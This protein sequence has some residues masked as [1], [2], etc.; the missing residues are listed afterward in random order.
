MKL[1]LTNDCTSGRR[2]WSAVFCPPPIKRA[3]CSSV[4]T[5]ASECSKLGLNRRGRSPYPRTN[6][7]R[8][9]ITVNACRTVVS[10][11]HKRERAYSG[12]VNESTA[13]TG[14]RTMIINII[15]TLN[16]EKVM[17]KRP[18]SISLGIS[19]GSQCG[20]ACASCLRGYG[21]S[22]RYLNKEGVSTNSAQPIKFGW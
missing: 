6:G 16:I 8:W 13:Y 14:R 1:C 19:I 12:E 17:V 15:G 7:N 9:P 4:S 22:F 2:H 21:R 20:H 10:M 11:A 3:A 5:D 18:T